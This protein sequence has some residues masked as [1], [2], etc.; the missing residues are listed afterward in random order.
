MT[1]RTK[2]A[3]PRQLVESHRNLVPH[4]GVSTAEVVYLDEDE[5][6]KLAEPSSPTATMAGAT[7]WRLHEWNRSFDWQ[8]VRSQRRILTDAQAREYDTL[9]WTVLEAVLPSQLCDQ[10]ATEG[11][12]C[13]R[14]TA[15]RLAKLKD[16]AFIARPEEITFTTHLVRQSKLYRDFYAS[17]LF[18]S[19]CWDLIGGRARLY[20]DQAVYKKPGVM[21][22]FPWHQDNGYTFVEPQQYITCWI[23]LDDADE[24]N[25]CLWMVP[26]YHLHGTLE[27][28]LT[29]LGYTCFDDAPDTAVPVA[30][31]A[32]SIVL[33]SSV[34][35]H[36]TGPNAT[37]AVRRALV[38]QFAPDGVTA[39]I[40]DSE[41]RLQRITA[42]DPTRQFLVIDE[43]PA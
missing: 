29:P 15:A 22:P 4:L 7:G 42:H 37:G 33:M 10:L 16:G 26:G 43:D 35:P 5:V 9:G 41:G 32:G 2:V 38:S 8:P 30:A 12:R 18:Q 3:V 34:T 23:A 14:R 13:E 25:G 24:D 27:H 31:K 6:I 39:I 1:I 21:D 28:K 19:I 11:D 36:E 20:W 17:E 40:K